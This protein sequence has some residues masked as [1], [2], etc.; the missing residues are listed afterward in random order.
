MP[1]RLCIY[2][3]LMFLLLGVAQGTVFFTIEG[4][5]LSVSDV[6]APFSPDLPSNGVSGIVQIP[7]PP[8]TCTVRPP[9]S[10]A[11]WIALLPAKCCLPSQLPGN[12]FQHQVRLAEDQGAAAVIVFGQLPPSALPANASEPEATPTIPAVTVGHSSGMNCFR[13]RQ[14]G[15]RCSAWLLSA[16]TTAVNSLLA[17]ALAT[18]LVLLS[19]AA[20]VVIV[21]RQVAA[22]EGARR[23]VVVRGLSVRQIAQLPTTTYRPHSAAATCAASRAGAPAQTPRPFRRAASMPHSAVDAPEAGYVPAATAHA[24]AI[25]RCEPFKP[26]L[27][28]ILSSATTGLHSSRATSALLDSDS[29]PPG[30]FSSPSPAHF[31][32]PSPHTC[33]RPGPSDRGVVSQALSQQAA[34]GGAPAAQA[35]RTTLID[36]STQ[37]T[38]DDPGPAGKQF[39]GVHACASDGAVCDAFADHAEGPAVW[40]ATGSLT[41]PRV[42]GEGAAS[43]AAACMASAGGTAAGSSAHGPLAARGGICRRASGAAGSRQGSGGAPCACQRGADAVTSR[44]GSAGG[45]REASVLCT[46]GCPFDAGEAA[47]PLLG[48]FAVMEAPNHVLDIAP[49][50]FGGEQGGKS[51]PWDGG[52]TQYVCSICLEDYEAGDSLRILPCQ[53]RYRGK[54]CSDDRL[55]VACAM[56]VGEAAVCAPAVK[57]VRCAGFTCCV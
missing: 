11:T 9:A 26:Q 42:A 45:C 49:M 23:A 44:A 20:M 3:L 46:L 38:A 39:A 52:A 5:R 16:T 2:S 10:G 56:F 7:E 33:A 36:G 47:E 28:V 41:T 13:T 50:A 18:G 31:L 17:S 12:S 27:S 55:C 25:P 8:H 29:C 43:A 4:V 21:Q 48:D 32:W 1:S 40:D 6:P 14:H 24:I 35:G 30:S 37:R 22:Q 54:P 53:H 34:A 15:F 19:F 57:C 51:R